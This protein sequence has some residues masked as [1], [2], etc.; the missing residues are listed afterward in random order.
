MKLSFLGVGLTVVILA[1]FIFWSRPLVPPSTPFFSAPVTST[2]TESIPPSQ[3]A[4]VVFKQQHLSLQNGRNLTLTIPNNYHLSVAA[5]GHKRLRFMAKSP[6][7][8][9]FVGEMESASDSSKG[10]VY[11]FDEFDT[12]T[13]IFK[14]GT[15]YLSN[16]RNP[17]SLTFYTDKTGQTWLYVALTDKL[18]R[19]KYTD[20]DTRPSSPAETIATFPDY[21]RPWSKGGWHLTRT[22]IA[23]DGKIY[24][25]VGSSCN[26]CEEKSE[27]PS[28]AAILQMNPDGSSQKIFASGLRNAV[29]IRF[30]NNKLFATVNGPDHLGDDKPEDTFIEVKE[31]KN[32]GWPYCYQLKGS[33]Y[34][35]TGEKWTHPIDC[36]QVPL[37]AYGFDPH[38]APL[39]FDLLD[40]VFLVALHGSGQKTLGI[41]YKIVAL[42]QK[43][44]SASDFITGFLQKGIVTGRPAAILANDDRSFFVTDDY[45]GAIYFVER[46]AVPS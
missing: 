10:H 16:Q 41:G 39:G 46:E 14:K 15:P 4:A 27:E 19:Y 12:K 44:Y 5:Q 31:G 40:G 2:S 23:H 37:A 34:A 11:V 29:G 42:D 38:S 18:V 1:G 13:K 35:D 20:G 17:N 33:I 45:N 3:P 25:S 9:L 6:D 22:V 7:N 26:S 32:Y 24:V 8:R 28:R 21:G 43:T 36:K 30:V